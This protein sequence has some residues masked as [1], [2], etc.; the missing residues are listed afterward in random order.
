VSPEGYTAAQLAQLLGTTADRV[1]AYARDG[2]VDARRGD[3]GEWRFS[4]Q[5]VVLLRTAEGLARDLPPGRVKQALRQ[6]RRQLPKGRALASL[7]IT[8][9]G[10]QVVV[11]EHGATIEA[12]TG[13][14]LLDFDTASLAHEAAPL[15]V[16]LARQAR[17][18]AEGRNADEWFELGE[19]L[20]A[21]STDEAEA[22][23]RRALELQPGHAHASINLGRLRHEAG[24]T[25]EA[26][27]L[28]LSALESDPEDVLAL[29]NLGVALEDLGRLNYARRCYEHVLRLDPAHA[30]AHYNASRLCERLGD[31]TSAMRHL[32][33]YRSLTRGA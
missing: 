27:Q 28:Y 25:Q 18:Q 10:D 22:A 15:A 1:R 23:Y 12:V 7:K 3:R 11:H 6:L 13:Q 32:M 31:K 33:S 8:S 14:A 26:A 20:E 17:E 4:F 19:E 21:C 29:F 24:D 30:D 16:E 9:E 5:D 2:F